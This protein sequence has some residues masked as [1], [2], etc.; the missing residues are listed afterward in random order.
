MA[1]MNGK[2]GVDISYANGN[3]DLAKVKNAGYEFVMIRCGYGSDMTS[4]DDSQF[5]SNVAKAEKLGMPWG[6]YLFSYA[7]S[8]DDAKSELAH[9]DRLLKAQ[10]AKGYRP[11]MPVA[12]DMEYSDYVKNHGGWNS[13]NL[14][15]VATIILDGLQK[16]GYYP[17]IYTG[18]SELA[19]LSNHIRNDFDCW[20]A[21]W[22]STPNAY[23][24]NRMGMWQY[25][26]ETNY[27]ESNSISGVGTI[28][29]NK[30]YKDYPTIIKN[31]G[32][33][34]FSKSASAPATTPTTTPAITEAQLR[35]KVA[36]TINGWLGATEGSAGHKEIL[37]IYN[38]Q[39]PLPVG[40]KMKDNDAWCAATVSAAWLKVGIAQYITTECGCGRFRDNAK[41]LGIWVENDAY[42]PKVGDAIIYYWS[43]NGVGDCQTGAD[44]IGIVTEVHG[45]TSFVVTEGNTGNGIVGKRTMQVNGKYIRGFIAP[46]Y[47]AIAKKVAGKV[48]A[49]TAPST[50]TTT[51]SS[52]S[53]P[54]VYYKVRTN[55]KWLPEVKNVELSY[56]DDFAGITGKA[57][58]DVAIK[59]DKGSIKYRVHV[60]GGGWLGWITKYDT[61]NSATGYAGNGKPIDAIEVYYY[62][63]SDLAKTNG[64]YK[65]KYRVSPV[66]KGYYSYQYDTE[67]TGGQDGYAGSFGK[68]IDRLQI[69]LSK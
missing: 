33:N 35:Q 26:G 47:A 53:A 23:K 56:G 27:L 52:K 5:A 39:N 54:N 43:D 25:G 2:R 36:N 12:L 37:A 46:D 13:S 19:M 18:Y 1:T 44:H 51:S 20:F 6:V 16:L 49:D 62:T 38:A 29:K 48:T 57:I 67:T 40:Y 42:V 65:A 63:P 68:T 28:D 10:K 22:N 7:C 14:T 3:I 61:S 58:T 34:G 60:K 66:G 21:Q 69:T 17:M 8:A 59:V 4:Q 50:A 31:G 55:G 30:C 41:K 45:T 15:N 32:Y 64:Y 11:T 24:Y 9:I